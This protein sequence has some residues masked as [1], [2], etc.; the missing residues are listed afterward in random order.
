MSENFISHLKTPLGLMSAICDDEGLLRLDWTQSPHPHAQD[1][2]PE[3]DVSRETISQLS[4]YLKG[5]RHHF[6]LALSS[7]AAS[8]SLLTWMKIIAQI[9]YGETAS[10]KELASL[11]G[12]EKASRAAGNA[13]QRNPIPIIIPC[14]RIIGSTGSFDRYS[15]GDRTT[16]TDPKNIAR[17]KAL[18]DLEAGL[19]MPLM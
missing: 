19:I 12:N 11:W 4:D 5:G 8:P 9:P 13:C 6:T 2:S 17:K 18:L 14:H 16:P 7:D 15:G 1:L 10:Y 3:N